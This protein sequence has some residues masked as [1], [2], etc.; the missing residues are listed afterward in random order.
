MS[1]IG[2]VVDRLRTCLEGWDWSSGPLLK[3]VAWDKGSRG[4]EG[5]APTPLFGVAVWGC[6]RGFLVSRLVLNSY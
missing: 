5:V 4:V 2:I 3:R 6:F 1:F